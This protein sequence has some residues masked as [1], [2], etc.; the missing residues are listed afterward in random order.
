MIAY[1]SRTGTKN[2]LA[3]LEAR[4]WRLLTSPVQAMTPPPLRYACDNGA[5]SAFQAAQ[6]NGGDPVL[7][8]DR[9]SRML[10]RLGAAA[11]F[12]IV[13]DVVADAART[14]ELTAA[15]LPKVLE[16]TTCALVAVQ[17]GMTPREVAPLLGPWGAASWWG[18]GWIPRSAI[19]RMDDGLPGILDG[20]LPGER[21]PHDVD[22]CR[23]LG[24]AVVPQAAEVAALALLEVLA[25]LEEAKRGSG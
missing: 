24:N 5:W 12:V 14:R 25:A 7:D 18:D 11:D 21:F 22:R 10:D 8:L 17:N 13:P 2:I 1:C 19:R 4:G 6:K 20:S 23:A 9:F 3:R 16:K 15:W